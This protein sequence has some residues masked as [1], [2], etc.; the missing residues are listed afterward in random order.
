MGLFD[1]INK[2]NNEQRSVKIVQEGGKE[3]TT[4][5]LKGLWASAIGARTEGAI[6]LKKLR[7]AVDEA[8][9]I[10]SVAARC[11]DLIVDT[12][13]AAELQVTT[14]TGEPVD[15][16]LEKI[17]NDSP[18]PSQSARLFKKAVWYRIYNHG[19]AIIILDRGNS[20]VDE[21]KTANLF[22]GNVKVNVSKPTA[23]APHGEIKY[24]E[25]EIA[26]DNWVK[27]APTEVLWLREPDPSEPWK[28]R[29]PMEAALESIGL[30][31]AARGWQAGQLANGANPGGIVYMGAEPDSPEGFYLAREEIES[32]LTGPSSAGRIAI[33]AGPVEPKWIPT[34]LNAQ[35]VAYLET[36]KITDEQIANALGVPLDLIG[37]NRTY[38]NVSEARKMFWEH[39]L[40]PK[41]EIIASEIN[42][43]AL[44]E[45]EYYATF[46]LSEVESL[47]ENKNAIAERVSKAVAEDIM[48]IDE[49]RAKLGLEPLP[50]GEGNVTLSRYRGALGISI[51]GG[52]L[53][54][55]A[56]AA[57]TGNRSVEENEKKEYRNV[58]QEEV[59]ITDVPQYIIDNAKRG[60]EYLKEGYGGD[61]LTD[62]TIRE[63]RQMADS[64][65]SEDKV[66]RMGPWIARHLVDLDA[67]KNNNPDDTE[68]PGAGLVAHL[69][70]G[71]GPD[72]ATSLRVKRW[73]ER[74]AAEYNKKHTGEGIHTRGLDEDEAEK[75]LDRLEEQTVRIVKRL[76]DAQQRDAIKRLERGERNNTIPASA[77]VTFNPEAW[78]ERAYEYLLPAITNALEKGVEITLTSLAVNPEG[79]ALDTY[80][81][82]AAD[83]RTKVLVD[84]VNKT[85][86][87]VLEDKLSAAALA[88]RITVD[89]YR[90]AL[91]STF[92]D[93]ST[94]RANTI[95][96]TEMVSSLNGAS[97]QVAVKSNVAMA[98]EWVATRDDLTRDS[99][100][101]LNGHRTQTMEDLYPNGL[102]YPGDP[103]G[104][105]EETVNCRCVEIYVTD[106]RK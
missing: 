8:I 37:G 62:K 103:R 19:Q 41:L 76:A 17:W 84:R 98:R 26:K 65:I 104:N 97:R 101:R 51:N 70:W 7:P 6:E 23:Y 32:A 20:R 48:T 69:L 79:L 100:A 56:F 72:K 52:A 28:S 46:D 85:T 83:E 22:Y 66:A 106:F 82:Q 54:D 88:D 63:A 43:Q 38:E 5:E 45:T 29:A 24:F 18:N 80:V 16:Y 40:I 68:Y 4:V 60:L 59:R 13:A 90:Q 71:S 47:Q 64:F 96:R 10:N 91:E 44:A 99:H 35:E 27:L 58:E 36:L 61:G 89:E 57:L 11:I 50:N 87:K 3:N 9:N 102:K 14:A 2:N 77:N 31:R 15:H 34:T 25:V 95:A 49:A 21:P 105:P 92:T 94:N 42:R 30:A 33:T 78:S 53:G 75:V 12:L 81:A 55:A 1:R 39:T 73:S 74:K 67:P 93:L 86:A